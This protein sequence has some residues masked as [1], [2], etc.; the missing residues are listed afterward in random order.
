MDGGSCTG[1]DVGAVVSVGCVGSVVTSVDSCVDSVEGCVDKT[2]LSAS[3]GLDIRTEDASTTNTSNN[4]TMI[5]IGLRCLRMVFPPAMLWQYYS[6]SRIKV[7][8][9]LRL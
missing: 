4:I 7:N 3:A 6:I 1:G 8:K 9:Q 2:E 5:L